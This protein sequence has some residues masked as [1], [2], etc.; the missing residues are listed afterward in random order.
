MRVEGRGGVES[1]IRWVRRRSTRRLVW[2]SVG[3][4]FCNLAIRRDF[5][6][7]SRASDGGREASIRRCGA[8]QEA[9]HRSGAR[10]A[11]EVREEVIEACRRVADDDDDVI[12]ADAFAIAL[13]ADEVERRP[14]WQRDEH[15]GEDRFVGRAIDLSLLPPATSRAAGATIRPR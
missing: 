14:E 1:I 9:E 3:A 6:V 5:P 15:L 13:R 7:K 10:I 11:V 4:D 2:Y 8:L 12:E